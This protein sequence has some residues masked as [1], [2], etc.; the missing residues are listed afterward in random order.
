MK[1]SALAHTK[2]RRLVR[3]L[4]VPTYAAVGIL[5]MLWHLTAREAPQGNIGKLED[6]DIADA[7]GWLDCPDRLISS[8]I[9]AGWL[10]ESR[11]HR[12]LVHDWHEHADDA[13]KKNLQRAKL[14]FLTGESVTPLSGK[15]YFVQLADS[16]KIGFTEGVVATRI[17]ALQTGSPEPLTLLA[18]IEGATRRDEI[19]LHKRFAPLAQTGEWFKAAE[20]LLSYIGE[21][22]ADDGGRRQ[23]T[24]DDGSLP[25]PEPEPEP[26]QAEPGP[27]LSPLGVDGPSPELDRSVFSRVLCERVGIFDM[28][29]QADVHKMFDS[30]MRHHTSTMGAAVQHI[31]SR[32]EQYQR[33]GPDLEW[34]YGS[35]H[36][37][38]MSGQ[39]DKPETWRRKDGNSGSRY[40]EAEREARKLLGI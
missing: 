1:R 10:D 6:A 28:R 26:S 9:E 30:Y 12:L 17:A 16:I 37:F 40:D 25:E 24:A 34:T 5:E 23:T 31:A 33:A 8:L 4:G 18:V 27:R 32:W 2:L 3:A 39:W 13:V 38:F 21:I 15:I 22:A 19:E 14:P 11:E 29:Q 20:P 35:A 36:K 7:V